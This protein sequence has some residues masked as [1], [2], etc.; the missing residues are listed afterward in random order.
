MKKYKIR[1]KNTL[2]M[3]RNIRVLHPRGTHVRR[4]VVQNTEI[5][6]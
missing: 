1:C 6:K 4:S 3:D 5:E 2:D